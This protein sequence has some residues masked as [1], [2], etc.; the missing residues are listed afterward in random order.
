MNEYAYV[1]VGY[2][3]NIYTDAPCRQESHTNFT[4]FKYKFLS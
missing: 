1:Y 4:L 3:F 2:L